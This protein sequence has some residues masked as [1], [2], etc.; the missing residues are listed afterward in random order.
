MVMLCAPNAITGTSNSTSLLLSGLPVSLR[1]S[2]LVLGFITC[3][4]NSGLSGRLT[5]A[6]IS[7]SG[8]IT[9]EIYDD[10]TDSPSSTGYTASG[11]KGLQAGWSLSYL[12][13]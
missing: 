8:Q 12:L 10:I 7:S 11:S 1:P 5:E 2:S 3:T 13:V 6:G 9:F 4:R